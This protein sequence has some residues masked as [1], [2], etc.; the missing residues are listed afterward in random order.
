M[1]GG[2]AAYPSSVV[3]NG[4]PAKVAGVKDIV[5]VSPPAKDGS[6]NLYLGSCS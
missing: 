4:V 2:R 6:M 1:P 5:M 3:M